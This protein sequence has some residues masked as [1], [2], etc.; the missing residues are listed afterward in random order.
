[1]KNYHIKGLSFLIFTLGIFSLEVPKWKIYFNLFLDRYF[2]DSHLSSYERKKTSTT[3]PQPPST[4]T[5]STTTTKTPIRKEES[6]ED[7]KNLCKMTAERKQTL[8]SL[9]PNEDEEK[10]DLISIED[11]I[12]NLAF[13]PAKLS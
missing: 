8:D 6:L 1:M 2:I 12:Y 11:D 4:L 3:S 5:S 10:N 13:R 7:L 9:K